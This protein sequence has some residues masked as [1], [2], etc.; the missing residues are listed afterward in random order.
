MNLMKFVKDMG[1]VVGGK[2]APEASDIE[3]HLKNTFGEKI[4]DL[5]VIYASGKVTLAGKCDS[6]ATQEKAILL[7]GNLKGVAEVYFNDFSAPKEV[8]ETEYYT[9]Q[10]GDTLWKIAQKFL[11]NGNKYPEIFE[12]NKEVI[13]DANLI[14][15]GQQIRIPK[16][17]VPKAQ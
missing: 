17:E 12:A 10:K 5:R 4:Q 6:R 13:K 8:G 15:P 9:I 3:T 14:Y 1:D 7:V 2:K 11:G 16:T